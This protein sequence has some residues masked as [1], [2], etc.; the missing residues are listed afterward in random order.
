M[1]PQRHRLSLY[2]QCYTE[3]IRQPEVI[4]FLRELKRHLRGQIIVILD[5]GRIHTG[6][7]LQLYCRKSDRIHLEY[8]PKYA[9]E[10]NPDEGVWRHTKSDLG[11]VVPKTQAELASRVTKALT[12]VGSSPERLRGCIHHARMT[13]FLS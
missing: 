5:N 2:F 4:E 1:S 8:F 13:P 9:P 7:L 6:K 10:L 3:N 12:K 11:N